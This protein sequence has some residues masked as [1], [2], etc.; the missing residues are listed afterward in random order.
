MG[1]LLEK[2]Y[3]IFLSIV[4]LSIIIGPATS[5][6]NIV[7]LSIIYLYFFFKFNNNKLLKNNNKN[8][9]LFNFILIP[10]IQLIYIFKF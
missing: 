2:F 9:N 6:I 5:L 1:K 10:Y 3:Y 4:P 8:K 7:I